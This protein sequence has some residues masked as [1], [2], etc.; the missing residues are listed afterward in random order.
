LGAT[1]I[2]EKTPQARIESPPNNLR[3][4]PYC[5]RPWRKKASILALQ[6][7]TRT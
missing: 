4:K 5:L 7:N 2:A 6:T 3:N 1:Q